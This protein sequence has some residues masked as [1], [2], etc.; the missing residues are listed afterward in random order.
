MKDDFDWQ[1]KRIERNREAARK[2]K[3]YHAEYNA[4]LAKRT[5]RIEV[6]SKQI[7]LLAAER[8]RILAEGFVHGQATKTTRKAR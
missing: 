6:L 5:K 2:A 1:I 3:A 7:S 8:E 4:W